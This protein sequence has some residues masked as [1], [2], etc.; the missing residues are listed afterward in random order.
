MF[1]FATSRPKL[2]VLFCFLCLIQEG[3]VYEEDEYLSFFN[4]RVLLY[5]VILHAEIIN[6]QRY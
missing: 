4:V 5:F 2:L 6:S 3:T 1:P